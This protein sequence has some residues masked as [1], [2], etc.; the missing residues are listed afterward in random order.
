MWTKCIY[1]SIYKLNII[2]GT[3]YI[4]YFTANIDTISFIFAL[5]LNCDFL[6]KEV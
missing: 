1:I 6:I 4:I 2:C 3:G 5:I